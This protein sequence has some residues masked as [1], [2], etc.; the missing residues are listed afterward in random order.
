[1][2]NKEITIYPPKQL[3]DSA[4]IKDF[5]EYQ[6]MYSES[7][8][9]PEQFW[10]KQADENIS[11]FK[12]WDTVIEHDFSSI[13]T[14]DKPYVKFFSGGRLNVSYNCLD[15]HINSWKRNKAAIIWQGEK[16]D[17]RRT[18]T[19]QELHTMVNRFCQCSQET[20]CKKRNGSHNIHAYDTRTA[21]R[22]A[23]LRPDRSYTL[24]SVF[25]I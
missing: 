13:G 7:I 1:M 10:A 19:F 8:T 6:K 9:K 2:K 3:S 21:N 5:N 22:H 4:Y 15:R 25:R 14:I 11:W 17:E 24:G 23:C 18:I 20:R 16:D 12:K